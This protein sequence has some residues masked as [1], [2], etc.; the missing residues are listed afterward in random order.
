MT[1]TTTDIARPRFARMYQRSAASAEQRGA[2]DHRKRLVAG[3]RGTIVE[4]GAGHGLNFPHYAPPVSEVISIEPEPTLRAQAE[5]AAATARVA[6]RV[7]AGVADELPVAD[8][9]ADAV[10]ASLVLCSVP[11]QQ[12][13][14]AEIARVLRPG[15]ELRTSTSSRATN[16]G[17]CCWRRST[18]AASGQRSPAAATRLVVPVFR[19]MFDTCTLTVLAL[20]NSSL[21]ISPFDRPATRNA[22]TSRSRP[23]SP[24]SRGSSAAAT[25]ATGSCKSIRAR[26]ANPSISATKGTAPSST[27]DP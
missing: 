18:A 25:A 3:L 15:G 24:A 23:V 8:A 14:L 7:V 1:E 20:M 9:S 2:G 21:A 5:S 27:A 26:R 22:N 16:R 12:R 4:I 10:V 11:D 6:V 13:A 19:R 17:G